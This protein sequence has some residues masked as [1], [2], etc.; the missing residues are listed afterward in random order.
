MKQALT[1]LWNRLDEGIDL[2]KEENAH[3]QNE[4][5]DL[6]KENQILRQSIAAGYKLTAQVS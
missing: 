2:Q 4:A 5:S 6:K 3:L 1:P